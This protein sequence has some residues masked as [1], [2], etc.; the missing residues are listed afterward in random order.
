[1]SEEVF[2]T[3]VPIHAMISRGIEGKSG[4]SPG[5]IDSPVFR[6]RAVMGL[7]GDM[8]SKP[9]Q[10]A[11]I[12]FRVDYTAGQPP[13]FLVQSAVAPVHVDEL[14]GAECRQLRLPDFLPGQPVI[15]RFSGN[16]V[17]RRRVPVDGRTKTQVTPVPYDHD[18]VAVENGF[19]TITP[20]LQ[21]KLSGAL[22]DIQLVNH[23][24][25]VLQEAAKGSPRMAIQ[26]DT[27][28]GAALVDDPETLKEILLQG[29]G[30]E[31]AYGCGMLSV[32]AVS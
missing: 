11:N 3:K 28:D 14:S 10:S 20:W 12:L 23:Q 6:H 27:F 7:F 25:E 31:K 2:L 32:K 13:Y 29:L 30:R 5:L 16:A 21:N 18:A 26:V 19:T 15:F 17:R 1:M 8:D 24:R 9:R 4:F 22:K